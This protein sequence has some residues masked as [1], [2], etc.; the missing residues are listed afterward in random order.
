MAQ[1]AAFP[2]T[3]KKHLLKWGTN[4]NGEGVYQADF[5]KDL[6]SICRQHQL[7]LVHSDDVYIPSDPEVKGGLYKIASRVY[8]RIGHRIDVNVVSVN[9]RKLST[10]MGETEYA[11]WCLL[12]TRDG[13]SLE[14]DL[15]K[16]FTG[17]YDFSK[18]QASVQTSSPLLYKKNMK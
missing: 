3:V 11:G 18:I 16:L 7:P 15:N 4:E 5:L 10:Q 17:K 1:I 8:S 6:D 2:G 13:S 9:V 14:Q 12:A